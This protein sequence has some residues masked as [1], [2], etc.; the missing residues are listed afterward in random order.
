MDVVAQLGQQVVDNLCQL[1]EILARADI[2]FAVI[3]ASA[4]LL[5]GVDLGRTTRDLDLAVAI[6]GG[7]D[8]ARPL[9]LDA[10]LTSTGIEHRFKMADGSEIDILAID[11]AW[12]PDHEIRLCAT[13]TQR[14]T[15]RSFS[16]QTVLMRSHSLMGSTLFIG[17]ARSEWARR[18]PCI[19]PPMT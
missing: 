14:S 19:R 1:N 15:L 7:L 8:A 9:L 17:R 18:T 5:H 10:G 4:F 6:E 12:T 3:G 2:P 11:P 13:R 16:A